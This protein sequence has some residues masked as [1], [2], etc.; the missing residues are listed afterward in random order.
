MNIVIIDCVAKNKEELSDYILR[1]C[2]EENLSFRQVSDRAAKKG[3]KI[4]QSY[5]SKIVSGAAQNLS[6]DKLIALAAGLNRSIEE[7]TAIAQGRVF[8]EDD[9]E[10]ATLKAIY[11]DYPKLTKKDRDEIRILLELIDNEIKK[12]LDK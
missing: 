5:I 9:V 2:R 1:V 4:A 6:S 10:D 7:V 12:R 8:K 11:F 3:H